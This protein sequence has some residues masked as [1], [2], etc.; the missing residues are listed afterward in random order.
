ML[1]PRC[2]HRA[3]TGSLP[4]VERACHAAGDVHPRRLESHRAAVRAGATVAVKVRFCPRVAGFYDEPS[5]TVVGVTSI[6]ISEGKLADCPR[7]PCALTGVASTGAV[8]SKA[9]HNTKH[10]VQSI[11]FIGSSPRQALDGS[12]IA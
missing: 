9:T 6:S 3:G 1:H 10:R 2:Q 4:R 11:D 7:W 5:V 8:L 12:I